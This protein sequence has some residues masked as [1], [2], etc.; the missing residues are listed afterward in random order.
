M[1]S[2]PR[3]IIALSIAA[4]PY[5]AAAQDPPTGGQEPPQGG[6]RGGRAQEPEIRPYERVITKDAR[7]DGGV[8]TVHRIKDRLYYEIPKDR[9]GREFLWV[10][11]IAKTTLGAGYGGQAAG[12]RV[13]KW[14]RRGDR[15]LLRAVSYDVVADTAAPIAKAVEA[16]NY[17]PIVMAFNIEALG[18]EDAAVIDVTRL[19]TSDV[20]EFS[21]R[22]RVG[23]RA[24]DASRS[25]VERAVSFP[26]NINVEA[27][28]TYNNPPQEA[29]GG[30]GGPPA[31]APGGG[32]GGTTLR[33][34]SH[35][36]LMHYSMVLLPE[37]PMQPRLF[38][39][40]VGY[41]SVRRLDYSQDEHRAPERRFITR[42]RLEK[43]DPKAELS[44]PVKPIVYWIDPA[45]PTKWVPYMKRGIESWQA[46]FEA[47][48]FKNAIL[49]K[50][51]PTPQQDP[52]WSPEDARYSVIR[53]L[54]S[55]IENA[56]GP[57][58]NDPRSG[59][60]LESDIQFYHN[61]MN[62]ARDWYF[63]QVGPLDPRA[64]KLPLPDDLMGRLIEYVAAHEVGHTLGF[65]HNMKA[66]SMYAAARVRDR[67]WVKKMGHTPTLMDYS[68]FNYVAQPED[69]IDL[70][71]LVP[72][73]GPYDKWATMWGYK[74][75]ASARSPEEEK[76]TLDEW[77]RHQDATPW[78][79]FST[80]GSAGADPG[81]LTEAVG[82]EDAVTSTTLGLKNLRRV[83][84]M[85]FTATTT[86][87]GE[88]FNDLEELYGR[89]LG[90]WALEMN[91]V[92]AIVGGFNSQQKHIGQQGLR[93]MP[94]SR[95]R[96]ANAVR[97]L[98]ENA[99][100]TPDWAI[101]PEILRRIEPI[102]VLDRVRTGQQRVLNSLLSNGRLA[103]L[104]EQDALDG[105]AAYRP[106]D[107]LADVRKGIWSEI[108][109]TG[110][111]V[112]DAY[113]RN[114]QRAYVETLADRINGTQAAAND[115]RAF[116]R[117]ELR[118]LEADLQTAL[119]RTTDRATRLHIEDVRSQIARALDPAVQAPAAASRATTDLTDDVFDPSVEPV[120][121][122]VDYSIRRR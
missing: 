13:V 82:D 73:I 18:K 71:D 15:I 41:F 114:L 66:S 22:T 90:Q 79:R 10:S 85:L 60:I 42:W 23:A 51:A 29:G 86:R 76:K 12:S 74:P 81:E 19:F 55:T 35:S 119:S 61:V 4:V 65:Q 56:S 54:P 100:A 46:A 83:S 121:C 108:Y 5:A 36:V 93:F 84:D 112:V 70:A 89:M 49:A 98:N 117:G 106:L 2:V 59:E 107:F 63:V 101:K 52:D 9:L 27:I 20:P 16:A 14:E 110:P 17:N 75:I 62:L 3:F 28:H 34:G 96:Q 111:A 69:N 87:P 1:K 105:A 38:D 30:R 99:F 77:A 48:G 50:E 44:E 47:A 91:H 26:E 64:R 68:R 8:F 7:S 33:P 120:S 118:T 102:G 115:A 31:P 95:D 78:L 21:G 6:G 92:A 57:H 32:R 39:E 24:F 113:R 58:I 97:F 122:W 11:Q 104:V 25:F 53:W 40:R 80:E 67:E 109:G 72:K 116:F 103:R 37:N 88:P 94:I 45:T 43:K